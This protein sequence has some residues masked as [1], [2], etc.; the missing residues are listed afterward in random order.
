MAK[1]GFSSNT[2]VRNLKSRQVEHE[3]VGSPVFEI[4]DDPTTKL[5]HMIGGGFFNEPRYYSNEGKDS[6]GMSEQAREVIATAKAV[7]ETATPEDLL[8]IANWVRTDLKI[9]TTP[10]ILLAIAASSEKGKPYL[11]K[12]APAVIQRADEIRQVFAAYNHLFNYKPDPNYGVKRVKGLPHSLAKG[13]RD[14]F[15]K[16]R[17]S[18]FLKYNTKERPTFGDVAL[19][20][21]EA[22]RLPKPLFEFLVNGKIIDEGATPVFAS[23][24]KLNAMTEFGPEAMDLAKKS[25]AT[26]ENLISQFGSKKEVWEYLIDSGLI[27]YMAMLRN[28]RNFEQVGISEMHWD[29]VF[30]KLTADRD[31]KQLPFRFLAARRNV[32]GP[33]AISAV[34]IA[35]DNAV[36][37]VPDIPGNTFIMV[38]SSGSMDQKVSDKSE[39]SVKDAGYALASILAKKCGRKA[40]IACFGTHMSVVPFSAA[41]STMTIINRM[42][43]HGQKVDHSTHAFLALHWLLAK[44]Y[45]GGRHESFF[46]YYTPKFLT[47]FPNKPMKVDRIIIVSDMCCYGSGRYDGNIGSL[48]N[49]YRRTVNPDARYYSINMAGHGQSQMD[50]QDDKTLLISGWSESIFTLIRE[51]EGLQE[52]AVEE[53]GETAVPSI[54]LLRERFKID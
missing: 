22:K 2:A 24:S 41:D 33:H 35:L 10:Q 27:K 1:V 25:F 34:D 53:G 26:W 36:Q 28:L 43:E 49:E 21:R 40:T 12:Y 14:A 38:D 29:K 32:T 30:D 48:L 42:E 13:L 47:A 17:E 11:R 8:V 50:P 7:L 20:I 15:L 3:H 16:F 6:Q 54:D 4:K 23:R 5:I 52:A 19:M 31:N 18:D 39:M 9:R 51:F 45:S 37:N 46:G 44:K